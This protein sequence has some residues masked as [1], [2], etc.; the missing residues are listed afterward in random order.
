LHGLRGGVAPAPR[1]GEQRFEQL[2]LL[3]IHLIGLQDRKALAGGSGGGNEQH[4]QRKDAGHRI[5]SHIADFLTRDF[6]PGSRPWLEGMSM[7]RMRSRCCPRA[8]SGHAAAPP[9]VVPSLRPQAAEMVSRTPVAPN[10]GFH[11]KLW[12]V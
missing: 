8:A 5:F 2:L 10:S 6:E 7:R 9:H 1:A 4:E 11:S 12:F 3:G